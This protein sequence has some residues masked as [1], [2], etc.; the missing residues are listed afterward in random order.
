MHIAHAPAHAQTPE[1]DLIQTQP[2][3]PRLPTKPALPRNL[4]GRE[5]IGPKG[6]HRSGKKANVTDD[7]NVNNESN[8][9]LIANAVMGED[10][11]AEQGRKA[12]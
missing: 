5:T 11:S 12:G 2:P 6:G 10:N 9:R 1:T 7:I 8:P 3:R 4:G